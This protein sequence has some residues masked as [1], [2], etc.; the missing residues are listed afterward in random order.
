MTTTL[1]GST[2]IPLNSSGK[3]DYL[4][5]RI[6]VGNGKGP[7]NYPLKQTVFHHDDIPT[8]KRKRREEVLEWSKS[9]VLQLNHH[10]W[11]KS[12]HPNKPVIERRTMENHVHDRSHQYQ[13]N[14]RAETVDSLRNVEPLDK[15]TKFHI[16][17]QLE[18]TAKAILEKRAQ[19]P[20]QRGQL[21]RTQEMPIHPDLE[22]KSWNN[23]TVLT[24]KELHKGLDDKTLHA[25]GWTKKVN[26]T[27]SKKKGY[28]SPM[29]STIL[30]QEEV[31]QQK[32][33]GTFSLKEKVLRPKSEPNGTLTFKNPLLN[34]KPLSAVF[35][36]H[37]GT[38][39]KN[40]YDNK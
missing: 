14:Y 6:Q 21:K 8:E 28:I 18:S 39:E 20:I 34:E 9:K 10:E 38:W 15:S 13:Y 16:S 36:E 3:F 37:S 19:S 31:R 12:T 32:S 11:S 2:N 30:F 7:I 27:L 24:T 26:S 4:K 29:Q 23:T 1:G 17:T 25:T 35:T 22:H 5:S 40:P 33:D